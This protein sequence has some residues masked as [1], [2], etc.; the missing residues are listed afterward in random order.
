MQKKVILMGAAVAAI[1]AAATAVAVAHDVPSLLED[2]SDVI[3]SVE[4]DA[5]SLTSRRVKRRR[6]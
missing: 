1:A 5:N 3:S 4:E 6:C 2:D